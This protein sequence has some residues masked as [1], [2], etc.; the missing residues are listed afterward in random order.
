MDPLFRKRNASDGDSGFDSALSS[1]S[2]SISLEDQQEYEKLSEEPINDLKS[3]LLPP[4]LRSLI[5]P[6]EDIF[7]DG[8]NPDLFSIIN[9][10]T[11]SQI[12]YKPP[13]RLK[14]TKAPPQYFTTFSSE[15]YLRCD[16]IPRSQLFQARLE[17]ELEKQIEKMDLV[18]VDLN[19]SSPDSKHP[20]SLGIRVIGVNM[21]HGIKDKLNIYVKRVLEDSVA[22][23]DGR[24]RVNDQIVEVNGVSLVGVGQKVAASSLSN[25]SV[26]P[27]T[28][29]VHFLLARPK[30]VKEVLDLVEDPQL[31]EYPH[32]VIG[33]GTSE[34]PG[35]AG[36][37]GNTGNTGTPGKKTKIDHDHPTQEKQK[38]EDEASSSDTKDVVDVGNLPQCV[39][40]KV[41]S[42]LN[43]GDMRSFAA[44]AGPRFE[45]RHAVRLL[46]KCPGDYL[47]MRSM[48]YGKT[49][50]RR[51]KECL[52]AGYLV[53][54]ATAISLSIPNNDLFV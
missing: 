46:G 2:S 10:V 22:G 40:R 49:L 5:T 3:S 21:I 15:E 38:P 36:T 23:H 11:G 30:E 50:N 42:F 25:C 1:R 31:P 26:L 4:S 53:A 54:L 27:E 6:D 47:V 43:E 29:T 41:E 12:L 17:Y 44:A 33:P 20:P 28:D 32:T 48:E 35:N 52:V 7:E 18:E 51:K 24:I 34:T 14:F 39:M 13:S 16:V 9:K 37:P 19:M 45:G 8:D